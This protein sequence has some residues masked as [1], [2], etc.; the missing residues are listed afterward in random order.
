MTIK[1]QDKISLEEIKK[2]PPEEA[3]TILDEYLKKNPKDEEALTIRGLRHWALNHRQL[4][5]NDYLAA[6]EINPGS[7][8]KMALQYANSIL[9]YYN[10]DLYNP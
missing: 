9:D 1:N 8:A 10:K 4:A 5:I 2:L 7:K 6:L 3:I